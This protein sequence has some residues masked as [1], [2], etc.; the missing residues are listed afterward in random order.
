M[1]Q[2]A[3]LRSAGFSDDEINGYAVEKQRTLTSA[4][5][6]PSEINDYLGNGSSPDVAAANNTFSKTVGNSLHAAASKMAPAG[7][8]LSDV[9]SVYAPIEAALNAGTGL[10][11]GFPA[12]VG[13]ALG[14]LVSKHLLG[15]DADPKELAETMS[16]VFTYQPHTEAG[17]RLSGNVMLPLTKLQ[18]GADWTGERAMDVANKVGV[19]DQYQPAIGAVTS[20]TIQMLAQ[21]LLGELGRKMGG[22]VIGNE[23]MTNTAKIVAGEDAKPADVSAVENSLRTTYAKTGIGP[24]TVMAEAAKDPAMKAE[25]L[26]PK[27]DVPTALQQYVVPDELAQ[28]PP[29]DGKPLLDV[30]GKTLE[31]TVA[32]PDIPTA[33]KPMQ[34]LSR[35]AADRLAHQFNIQG[36]P[37]EVIEH[38]TEPEKF[39]IL[40]TEQSSPVSA[41]IESPPLDTI[42]A[43][44]QPNLEAPRG[45]DHPEIRDALQQMANNESGWAEVGGKLIRTPNSEVS[46]DEVISRTKWIP[47]EEWWADI[48]GP[49]RLNPV[50]TIEAVRKAIA[51]EKLNA[52]EARTVEF[53]R[54]I[55]NDRLDAVQQLGPDEFHAT[56]HDVKLA[57][58]PP[59]TENVFDSHAVARAMALN[60]DAVNAATE[61]YNVHDSDAQFM[62]DI[63]GIINEQ[64]KSSESDQGSAGNTGEAAGTEPGSAEYAA[65]NQ[66]SSRPER[67]I[68]VG[69]L[70]AGFNPAEAI[71]SVATGYS[72]Y[73]G[74]DRAVK[75]A[76]GKSP[77]LDSLQKIFA[78]AARGEIAQEQAGIMRA[79]FGKMAH[80]NEL[81]QT[82]LLDYAKT[83]DKMPVAEN[84]KFIDAYEHGT[85]LTDAKLSD[86]AKALHDMNNGLRVQIQELGKGQLENFDENY[87]GRIWKDPETANRDLYARRPI[88][89]NKNFLKARTI[90]YYTDGL[91]WRAYDADDGF[92][93]SFDTENEARMAAGTDG[94]VGQPLEPITTNPVEMALLKGKE[95]RKY[96]YGQNIF[97]EMKDSGLAKFVRFGNAPP[98]SWT[99]I[100]DKIARVYQYSEDES[101][102]IMRGEYYAPD[103]AA[104]LINNH[105]SP[106][107]A[108]NSFYDAW[109]GIGMAMNSLQLG[110]SA[111]HVG[112]TTLDAMTSRVALGVKQISRGDVMSGAGN[113]AMGIS[114]AQ[115]FIN[116]YNGD[117]LLRAYL[118][119]LDS[120]ELA[121]IVDAIEQA[122]GKVKMDDFYRNTTVNAFKQAIRNEDYVGAAKSFLPTILDRISAPILEQ[123]VPRQKLGVYFDMAKDWIEKNPDTDVETKRAGLGKLWDSVDNRMG[124]LVYD[125]VFWNR[126]LKDGLMATVRSVGWNLGTFR[127]L[128]GGLLDIKDIPK[129]GGF[130]D[131][132]AY[133]VA[134]P[135]VAA[136]YGA[137]LGYAY[138]GQLPETLK[139]AFYPKT[140]RLRPDGSDDR[141]SLPTYMKDIF[142]YGEDAKN[143]V[144]YGSDP[145][146]TLKNKAHPLISTVSQML[147]NEDFYG[148]SIRNPS[149][150]A[151]QQIMDE[152]NY[153]LKQIE[154]FSLRNY[155]QQAKLK[156]EDPSVAGYFS[157]PSMVG[158]T[159]APGYITKSPEQLE[160][161]QV[162]HLR[163][164]L[165]KKFRE[166]IQGGADVDKLIPAMVNAGLTRQDIKNV[167]KS[168][169]QQQRPHR[170]KSFGKYDAITEE[171]AAALNEQ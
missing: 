134:L 85:P 157:S 29:A 53:M 116:I 15:L 82:Y 97:G 36:M 48:P 20:S 150:P 168:A 117:R 160:S 23:D 156:G 39:A 108:G 59:T 33:D 30:S 104:T 74:V 7:Q 44:G 148:A 113:V 109:R 107:L 35:T 133:V 147:N 99:K 45:I 126:A 67:P 62:L 119:K 171:R 166:D 165:M 155:Q 89:G 159:P 19:P 93:K 115:P 16:K 64:I 140:G 5:F 26:D 21:V 9:G 77:L 3:A 90:P 152:A 4:G 114:P 158:I 49:S 28:L 69:T 83:F 123:L 137:M 125:N 14:G 11:F 96:I 40:P 27:V 127:E 131:R 142:A 136:T 144:K 170:L 141:V 24:Y 71:K 58:L 80:E 111:F 162:S 105:L 2:L 37:T 75:V 154:P 51:G 167:I 65:A 138:T 47:K 146:Q 164:P 70:N 63:R 31:E 101:G 84:V 145:T 161:S 151:V 118:G 78:P 98:D 73:V 94:R 129:L 124:Q 52:S 110:L 149:A 143:F 13:G 43:A 81:A 18:E 121:P 46:G 128:G 61:R 38:P 91:R 57:G 32:Q 54:K 169:S 135:L 153:V 1:G 122:G 130:S 163:D 92:I 95:M 139:D 72:P 56:M 41:K 86:A 132:T 79:N 17:L 88:E 8:T 100:N 12:Y 76:A 68:A 10:L 103:Q 25:L 22:Q 66:P 50:Q 60:P 112:F 102:M 42:L 55:A 120:P 6:S 34:A 106:G 87:L